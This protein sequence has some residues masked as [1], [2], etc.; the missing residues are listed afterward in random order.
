MTWNSLAFGIGLL[1]LATAPDLIAA[2]NPP[3][4]TGMD[5]KF[6]PKTEYTLLSAIG[7]FTAWENDRNPE[8]R[9]AMTYENLR[10][11]F[12]GTADVDIGI[13]KLLSFVSSG[14]TTCTVTTAPKVC[15]VRSAASTPT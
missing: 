13:N 9:V 11:R 8:K 1:A 5:Y 14:T 12:D 15:I 10:G 4:P 6:G 2:E 3:L 7:I